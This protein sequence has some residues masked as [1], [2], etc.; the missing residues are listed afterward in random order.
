M[1]SIMSP[2]SPHPSASLKKGGQG[3]PNRGK[4]LAADQKPAGVP[5]EYAISLGPIG[6]SAKS[7]RTARLSDPAHQLRRDIEAG[8]RRTVASV[9]SFSTFSLS[10]V[11]A[12]KKSA[13]QRSTA[14]GFVIKGSTSFLARE[15]TTATNRSG[16]RLFSS[17]SV[18]WASPGRCPVCFIRSARW[19]RLNHLAGLDHPGPAG[20]G[21][22]VAPQLVHQG[23][24]VLRILSPVGIVMLY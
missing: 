20:P 2:S 21:R 13:D 23:Q 16:R 17:C 1:L 10:S 6:R 9:W 12:E 5:M 15:K 8:R 11:I 18:N 4:S 14:S 3:R 7:T 19:R 24:V 22:G